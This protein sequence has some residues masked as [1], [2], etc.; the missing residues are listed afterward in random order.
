MIENGEGKRGEEGEGTCLPSPLP[1][2]ATAFNTGFLGGR[3]KFIEMAVIS[4]DC[5]ELELSAIDT[6]SMNASHWE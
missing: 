5:Y 4:N 3:G 2:Y 6:V 1:G